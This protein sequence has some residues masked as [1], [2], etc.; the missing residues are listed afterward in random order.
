MESLAVPGLWPGPARVHCSVGSLPR[1]SSSQLSIAVSLALCGA[2]SAFARRTAWYLRPGPGQRLEVTRTPIP[3]AANSTPAATPTQGQRVVV[4]SVIS[5]STELSPATPVS[6]LTLGI[7][8]PAGSR[9]AEKEAST[10][11]RP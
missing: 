11:E 4:A 9:M 3:A 6:V 7:A 10:T 5:A 2:A 8:A 1:L